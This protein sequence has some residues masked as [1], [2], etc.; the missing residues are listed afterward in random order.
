LFNLDLIF[1]NVALFLFKKS[2][3]WIIF[4]WQNSFIV[5]ACETKA[6]TA[7]RD[8]FHVRIF[9]TVK[10]GQLVCLK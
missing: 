4:P 6:G 2:L 8:M 7:V 3:L 1:S 10:W 5:D 9:K